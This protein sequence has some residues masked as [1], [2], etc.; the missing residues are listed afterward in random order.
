[1]KRTVILSLALCLALAGCAGPAAPAASSGPAGA[2]S[3]ESAA[4]AAPALRDLLPARNA[5]CPGTEG[6]YLTGT[7]DGEALVGT[8]LRWDTGEQTVLCGEPGCSHDSDSCPAWL[9]ALSAGAQGRVLEAGGRLYWLA[10]DESGC[11]VTVSGTAGGPRTPLAD[12]PVTDLQSAYTDGEFLYLLWVRD[13]YETLLTRLDPATGETADCAVR[14]GS[15]WPIGTWGDRVVVE[16]TQGGVAALAPD[17][18]VTPLAVP[19]GA[20]A[21]RADGG[22]L[23]AA[24]ADGSGLALTARPLD[25]PDAAPETLAELPGCDPV[26]A[27]LGPVY[28]GQLELT[29]SEARQVRAYW[30][31][32][33]GGMQELPAVTMKDGTS[34]RPV[35]IHTGND[36]WLW[37]TTGLRDETFTAIHDDGTLYTATRP[38]ELTGLTTPADLADPDAAPRP[39]TRLGE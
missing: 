12:L 30:V 19:D 38:V 37:V 13:S 10:L 7:P 11:T 22:R 27:A 20:M 21:L 9:G 3:A 29:V 24:V 8:V 33:G 5:Y 39:C 14:T 31:G 15:A 6:V 36:Q 17:G 26:G 1:M 4:A 34:P 32:T 25:T 23:Y 18:T 2:A 16:D 28:G 35:E